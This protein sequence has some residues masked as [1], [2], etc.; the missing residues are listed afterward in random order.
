MAL[1]RV[2]IDPGRAAIVRLLNRRVRVAPWTP[3]CLLLCLRVLMQHATAVHFIL[4][5]QMENSWATLNPAEGLALAG[6]KFLIICDIHGG[7][8]ATGDTNAP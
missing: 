4:M 6:Q 3:A 1:A 5:S 7:K 8:W 2:G